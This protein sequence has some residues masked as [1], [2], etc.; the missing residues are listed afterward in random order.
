MQKRNLLLPML[1]TVIFMTTLSSCQNKDNYINSYGVF[2]GTTQS[3][4]TIK[5][6]KEYKTIV[7]E[8]E[9]FDKETINQLLND[10][11]KVYTYLSVG[12]LETYRD[13]YDEFKDATFMDYENWKE[14]RWI[15]VS[16]EGWKEH[17]IETAQNSGSTYLFLD[18]YDVYYIAKDEYQY[19]DGYLAD[20]IYKG[21]KDITKSLYDLGFTLMLNSGYDFLETLYLNN[22]T[23]Y[24][25]MIDGYNQETV[26]SSI[27]DYDNDQFGANS[28][29]DH[30]Y[31]LDVIDEVNNTYHIPNIYLLEYPTD[32]ELIKNIHSYCKTNN[33]QYYISSKVNLD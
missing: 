14:E 18:N 21:L 13:Y 12:S 7:I 33:Y 31:Y 28:K 1:G 26:F 24:L 5:R 15:D 25:K 20:N 11:I 4:E 22:E 9:E 6:S 30:Q 10:N 27:L 19:G 29:E 16:T 23:S 8:P 3:E 32:S 17:I 2:L